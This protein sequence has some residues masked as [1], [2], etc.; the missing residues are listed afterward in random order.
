LNFSRRCETINLNSCNLSIR[1]NVVVEA[2]GF[3][4]NYIKTFFD[5]T[6]LALRVRRVCLNK[7]LKV[8]HDPQASLTHLK[9][10]GGD[11]PSGI[12]EYIIA[13]RH[14]WMVWIYFFVSNFGLYAYREILI[15]LKSVVFRR[16][17]LFR[18]RYLGIAF[19]E[20]IFGF[21]LA[22]KAIKKGRKLGFP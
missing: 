14:A 7:G 8:V 6:D 17:N 5:D 15:R 10:E 20:F 2:G 18:P 21:S 3:D 22:L 1:K 13:D 11:R 9:S 16:V 19:A 4:E 12:N